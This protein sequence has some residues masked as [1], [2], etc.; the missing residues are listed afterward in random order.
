METKQLQKIADTLRYEAVRMVWEGKD[1]HPGP[2]LSIADIVTTLYFDEMNID[3]DNPGWEDRD[4]FILSKGHACPI[5]YAALNEKGYFTEKIEHFNL[6]ALHSDFQGHPVSQKTVGIDS[7]SGSLGNGIAIGAGMAIAGKFHKKDYRVFVVV[8]DGE[9]QEGVVWEGINVASSH[10][11]DNL[12][13]FV[14]RN[15]WQSGGSVEDVIGGNNVAQR[16]GAFGWHT[17]EID[18]ND[19]D[20]IKKALAEANSVKGKPIAIVADCIKGKGLDFMENDNAWHK[21]VPTDEQF[22]QAGIQLKGDA[23]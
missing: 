18:G 10:K 19:I 4:R 12:I 2:A 14:D 16:I 6:R 20:Q 3:P 1:G 17:I 13:V 5:I 9:L 7:T 23:K 22:R 15:G 8:G 11:L 21:G